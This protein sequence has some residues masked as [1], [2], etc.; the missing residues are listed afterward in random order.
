[1]SIFPNYVLKAIEMLENNHFEAYVVGG[2]VRDFLINKQASDYDITTNALPMQIKQIFN[3]YKIITTG[4]KHGTISVIID[5]QILEITTYR[6]DGIYF[7]NRHPKSISFSSDLYEDLK[8]RDFTINA[9]A[10]NKNGEIIDIF[11]GKKDIEN[12]IIRTVGSADKRFQ[13]DALRIIRCLRFGSTLNFN[14]DIETSQSVHKYAY[15]LKNISAERIK[16]EFVKLLCGSNCEK[17]LRDYADVI[18]VFI[19]EIKN[20]YGFDQCTPYHKYD[21]WEHTLHAIGISEDSP[22][23][24][25][26]MFFHDI[27]KPHCFTLDDK[28]IGHFKGHAAL[29]AEKTKIILERMK[30][31]KK[32]INN[33]TKI[34]ANHRYSYKCDADVKKIMNIMGQKL[35]FELIKVKRADDA[36]KGFSNESDN[37]QLD[38]AENRAKE[39]IKN[40]ECYRICDMKINGNDLLKLGFKGI[41]IKKTLNLILEKIIYG[42]LHNKRK[43]LINYAI[44][45]K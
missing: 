33:I 43:Q 3:K 6:I 34:I 44:S 12:K 32:E 15:L 38:F 35:F 23:I 27:A 20:M 7:D 26:V 36:S 8:R 13:E 21:V 14:I 18:E 4:E 10:Q 42:E 40:H 1:M 30:F 9:M 11:N 16:S 5:G 19:P 28:G 37:I 17:I 24:R 2:S 45:I 22:L 39:I 31:S 41:Q 29:G 25:L